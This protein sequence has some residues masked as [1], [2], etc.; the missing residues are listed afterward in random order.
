MSTWDEPSIEATFNEVVANHGIKK[1]E[2]ML[3]FRIMLVGGKFGPGVFA[4]AELIKKEHCI[5]RIQ[6]AMQQ[7]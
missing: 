7:L 5:K 3:P 2:V 6:F 4:I 1:G